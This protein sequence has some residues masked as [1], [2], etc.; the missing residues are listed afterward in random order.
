MGVFGVR[1]SVCGCV[2]VCV[3]VSLLTVESNEKEV[4]KGNKN[5]QIIIISI[6]IITKLTRLLCI[7]VGC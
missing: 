1:V 7:A 6:T 4:A 2:G 3:W 5:N